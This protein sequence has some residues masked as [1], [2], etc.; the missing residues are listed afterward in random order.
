MMGQ[1]GYL[2]GRRILRRGDEIKHA[3]RQGKNYHRWT[4]DLIKDNL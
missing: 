1:V 4:K 3:W 2:R